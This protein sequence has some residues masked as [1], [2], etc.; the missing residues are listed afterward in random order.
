MV[1]RDRRLT[2]YDENLNGTRTGVVE[3][4]LK[5]GGG[6]IKAQVE[7][8]YD[9]LYR[10]THEHRTALNQGDD[11]GVAYEYNFAYD[12]AGNRTAWQ[13]VGVGTTYYGYDAANELTGY[14]PSGPP[15]GTTL[16][17]DDK[18][19][20][21]FETNG[22]T[23][24]EYTWDLQNRMTQWQKTN[25]T[26][27]T[28]LYN[29]DGMR[30]RKTPQGGDQT[31]FLLDFAEIAEEI[32]GGSVTS[33][34]GRRLTSKITSDTRTIYHSD[35]VGTT[36]GMSDSTQAVSVA[37]VYDAYGN[38][39]ISSGTAPSFGFAG[40]YRYYTDSTGLQYLKARYYYSAVGRFLSRDPAKHGLNWYTYVGNRPTMAVDPSGMVTK[41]QCYE[42]YMD[43]LQA[44]ADFN[45]QCLKD[46]AE[47]L[48]QCYGKCDVLPWIPFKVPLTQ[49]GGALCY[50]GCAA[51]A[52][53][54]TNL[55]TQEYNNA[56]DAADA[57]LAN[58]L[59]Q[60]KDYCPRM[61]G[62]PLPRP[63]PG[64]PPLPPLLPSRPDPFVPL[65]L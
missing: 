29:A 5:P 54:G 23:V 28:Y 34:V 24:T 33:Y 46:V 3:Q 7:Y 20:T 19:N 55:C 49:L 15:Y 56:M 45:A 64:Q 38:M 65:S 8:G 62:H 61:P 43:L 27:E 2:K 25:Q 12:A 52:I 35:G 18:G 59:A 58:C 36:R 31:N 37:L 50:E 22:S 1:A 21:R 30:V 14:G 44:A 53:Y 51:A 42:M 16:T 6:Y 26:T 41:R 60:A 47:N 13:E 63:K 17:Y 48:R 10:L 40:H 4:I 32:T 39:L 57:F 11:P 9:N